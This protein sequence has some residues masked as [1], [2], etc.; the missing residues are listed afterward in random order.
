MDEIRMSDNYRDLSTSGGFQFEF[1]CERCRESWRSPFE[2]YVPGTLGGL[3]DAADGLLGGMFGGAR[4]AL[5]ARATAGYS[6]AKDGGLER[7]VVAARGHFHRCPRCSNNFCA[8]CWNADEG[9]CIGCV[10]RLEAAVA[11]INRDAKIEKARAVA[12]ARATVSDADLQT[13][14]VSCPA[15]HAPVGQGKFCPECGATVSLTRACGACAAQVPRAAKFCP[16]CG[17]HA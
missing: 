17:A 14:V 3:L 13:R 4:N 2:R 16:E 12:F 1:Y 11:A 8:D 10:P 15:C 9:T 7:A 5:N 6:T